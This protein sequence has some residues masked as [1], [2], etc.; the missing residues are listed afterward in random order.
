[1]RKLRFS[2][3]NGTK[4]RFIFQKCQKRFWVECFKVGGS[5]HRK[6]FL[7]VDGLINSDLEIWNWVLFNRFITQ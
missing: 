6:H 4:K 5:G 2:D 1:M 3:E 7:S